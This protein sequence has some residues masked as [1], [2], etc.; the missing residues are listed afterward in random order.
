M[1]VIWLNKRNWRH[2]GPIVNMALHNAHSFASIGTECHFVVGAGREAASDTNLDLTQFYGLEPHPRL[3]IHR[4]RLARR[5]QKST[6]S[7]TVFAKAYQL[8]C[9]LAHSDQVAIFCRDSSFLPLLAWLCRNPRILGF[10]ELHDY[11]ADHAWR[12]GAVLFG[13][14]REWTLERIFL[15]RISGLVCITSDQQRFY[16]KHFPRLPSV[17]RSLGTKP[18]PAAEPEIKRLA[19]TVFYVGHMNQAKGASFLLDAAVELARRGIRT[20]FWGGYE[21]NVAQIRACA[22]RAGVESMIRA[23]AFRPPADLHRALAKRG[24]IGV[25]MLEDTFYNRHLTCPVK[26]LDYLSHGMPAIGTPLTSVREVLGAAGCYV[27]E[28]D[29]AGFVKKVAEMFDD[30]VAYANACAASRARAAE[31]TWQKR[32]QTLL[33]F[34]QSLWS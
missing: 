12:N 7:V 30:P 16:Q 24:G 31:L 27:P 33:G 10:Y 9:R 32:A 13:H 6:S 18:F 4:V 23:E 5:G 14:W 15:P 2:P 8:A 3:H 29:M 19:R 28:G 1:K 21:R 11:Y 26:A 34:A 17:V 20:E 22:V 25:V